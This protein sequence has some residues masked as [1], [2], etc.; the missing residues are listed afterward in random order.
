MGKQIYRIAKNYAVFTRFK[1]FY[2]YYF[3]RYPS[4]YRRF[5]PFAKPLTL[6]IHLADNRAVVDMEQ[7]FLFNRIPKAAN[8]T[9]MGNLYQHM[10]EENGVSLQTIA[11]A[12]KSHSVVPSELRREDAEK[13]VSALRSRNRNSRRMARQSGRTPVNKRRGLIWPAHMIWAM[14]C[15]RKQRM[16]RF[17]CP[18]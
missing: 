12:R 18:G 14:P 1:P 8:T 7:N 13:M 3:S 17:N 5:S 16:A 6:G 10:G 9:L 11:A 4:F 15:W 2:R